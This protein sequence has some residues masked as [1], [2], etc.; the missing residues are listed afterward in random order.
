M[1]KIANLKDKNDDLVYPITKADAAYRSDNTTTVETS[2]LNAAYVD[3]NSPTPTPIVPDITASRIQDGAVTTAKIAGGAVTSDKVDFTTLPAVVYIGRIG[4]NKRA[5]NN[6]Y[7]VLE[8]KIDLFSAPDVST[9]LTN[10]SLYLQLN[11]PSSGRFVADI[12]SSLW[13]SNNTWDYMLLQNR[14]NTTIFSRAMGYKG[15][16][17][18]FVASRGLVEVANGDTIQVYLMTNG[19]SFSD[20]NLSANDSKLQLIIYR[21]G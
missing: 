1:P 14:K 10:N 8:N 6:G 16:N 5:Y 12:D 4:F 3:D 15:G 17:W 13:V 2:L 9:G 20:G 11:L 19:N 7:L 21:V 18:G